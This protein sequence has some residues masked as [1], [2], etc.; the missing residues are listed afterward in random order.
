MHKLL[1]L[2]VTL[3]SSH[4]V[5]ANNGGVEKKGEPMIS[6][7]VTDANSKKPIADVSITAIHTITKAEHT[8]S[9]DING[10]FKISQLP[11][12]TYKFKFDKDNYKPIEKNN[13]TVKSE[14]TTKLNIELNN[15]KDEELEDSRN[16]NL[17]FGF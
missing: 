2:F 6:G 17:K 11:L 1:L 9:T 7:T 4:W 5:M 3:I 13:I 16:W 10:N 12:G 15:Y 14:N 8:I